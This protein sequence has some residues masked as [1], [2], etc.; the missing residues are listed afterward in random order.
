[1]TIT[2]NDVDSANI[3]GATVQ[4]TG[5]YI[6]GE[7]LLGFANTASITG[8]FVAGT[9]TLTLSGTDSLANYQTALRSVTYA[10]SSDNPNTSQRTLTFIATDTSAGA[11]AGA[12]SAVNI[13]AVDDAPVITRP[14]TANTNEDTALTFNG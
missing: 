1:N 6:N 11:S 14:A 7:D 2:V 13:T 4:I 9:G 10:N 5:N 8:N 12:T 3:T